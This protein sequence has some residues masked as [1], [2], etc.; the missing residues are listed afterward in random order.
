MSSGDILFEGTVLT[1]EKT[2]E[3]ESGWV[4][5]KGVRTL[6]NLSLVPGIKPG[7]KAL[8]CGRVALSCLEEN[9]EIRR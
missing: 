5:H 9:N 3:G 4:E 2:P 7:K 1:V 8:V 6:V